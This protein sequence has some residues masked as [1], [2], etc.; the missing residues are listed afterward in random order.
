MYYRNNK[1]KYR[2]ENFKG[3]FKIIN[4][5]FFF[6]FILFLLLSYNADGE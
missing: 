6:I 5:L 3:G 4:T 2:S 1:C